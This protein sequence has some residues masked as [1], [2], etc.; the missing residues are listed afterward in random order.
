MKTKRFVVFA[1]AAVLLLVS[2]PVFAHHGASQY[3]TVHSKTLTATVT[4][5]VWSNPHCILSFDAKNDEGGVTHWSVEMH[6]PTLLARAGWTSKTLKP[7]D[8]IQVTFHAAKN[9]SGSGMLYGADTK[10]SL[11]GTELPLEIGGD[12]GAN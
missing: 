6:N 4:D 10:L 11:H 3:D 8:E 5:F 9:G 7:G 1:L 12:A 2:A